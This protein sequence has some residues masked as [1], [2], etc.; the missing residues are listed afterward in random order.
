M[1]KTKNP[2]AARIIVNAHA[3]GGDD[4]RVQREE[5]GVVAQ[6]VAVGDHGVVREPGGE[7]GGDEEADAAD[8]ERGVGGDRRQQDRRDD[9]GR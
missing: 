2:T 1:P 8:G 5:L 3:V 7:D 9:R 4:R 6:F